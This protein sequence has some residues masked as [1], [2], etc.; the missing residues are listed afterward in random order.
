MKKNK[1]S[2]TVTGNRNAWCEPHLVHGQVKGPQA[3]KNHT[4]LEGIHQHG[5]QAQERPEEA[6][7]LHGRVRVQTQ[8]GS[9]PQQAGG[10]Q[11]LVPQRFA[12][13]AQLPACR[14]QTIVAVETYE[15]KS[16][17]AGLNQNTWQH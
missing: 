6:Q 16:I 14:Q 13:V 9:E 4:V 15:K 17:C 3:E 7:E 11:E 2:R 5:A 12:T 1:R 8:Q 10:G